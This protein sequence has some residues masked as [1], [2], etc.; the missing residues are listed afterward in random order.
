MFKLR[1]KKERKVGL[2]KTVTKGGKF[3]KGEA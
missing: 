1:V 3:E 2:K